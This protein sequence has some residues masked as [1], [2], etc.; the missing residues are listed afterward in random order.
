M[1]D[2]D[3]TAG[4]DDLDVQDGQPLPNREVMSIVTPGEPQPLP[5]FDA[6]TDLLS[7]EPTSTESKPDT[8]R[9]PLRGGEQN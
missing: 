8:I 9:E 5:V 4:T 1:T 6:G 2:Q 7:D 3:R